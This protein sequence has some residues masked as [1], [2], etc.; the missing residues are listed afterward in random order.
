MAGPEINAGSKEGADV[1]LATQNGRTLGVRNNWRSANLEPVDMVSL[2]LSFP[3][4]AATPTPVFPD[5]DC[6]AKRN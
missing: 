1:L 5:A 3:Y 4:K 6:F 2:T